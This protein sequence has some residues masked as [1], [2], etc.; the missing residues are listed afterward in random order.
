MFLD[1]MGETAV[2]RLFPTTCLLLA[3]ACRAYAG[4]GKGDSENTALETMAIAFAALG[5]LGRMNGMAD[6]T[7]EQRAELE[8]I[9]ATLEAA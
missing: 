2:L 4:N 1:A 3:R 5:A 6:F 8:R 9:C 7:P